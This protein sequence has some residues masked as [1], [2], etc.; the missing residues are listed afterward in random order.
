MKNQAFYDELNKQ[1]Y[2]P[3]IHFDDKTGKPFVGYSIEYFTTLTARK[4]VEVGTI[5]EKDGKKYEVMTNTEVVQVELK[6]V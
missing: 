1:N 3:H 6:E 4:A 5:I 2:K